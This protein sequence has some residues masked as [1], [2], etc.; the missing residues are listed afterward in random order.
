[1][2][3]AALLLSPSFSS[4][5]NH[6]QLPSS[7]LSP[8][9]LFTLSDPLFIHSIMGYTFDIE[10]ETDQPFV[11]VLD[12]D[13]HVQ[14]LNGAI[15]LHLDKPESFKLATV[16]IHGHGKYTKRTTINDAYSNIAL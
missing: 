4:P 15:V 6:R 12:Q 10:L 11:V 16:A 1:M 14:T 9:S 8:F 13:S 3:L 2:G 5:S 7:F